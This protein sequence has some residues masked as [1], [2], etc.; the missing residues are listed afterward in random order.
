M[1]IS[2]RT[3]AVVERFEGRGVDHG[4]VDVVG[5]EPFG[6]L[7]RPH[8]HQAAGDEDD[9]ASGSQHL[10]LAELEGVVVLVEHVGTLPR[11]RRR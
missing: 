4:D 1:S 5:G 11:S 7:Q 2:A 10:G 8:G 6:S 3:V 9:V